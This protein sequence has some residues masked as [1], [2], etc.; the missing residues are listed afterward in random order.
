M[1]ASTLALLALQTG[2]ATATDPRTHYDVLAYRLELAFDPGARAMTASAGKR[3]IRSAR[4]QAVWT[5]NQS[6]R[7]TKAAMET[8]DSTS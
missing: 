1:I 6:L 4:A 7:P 2:S 8:V 3:L 5:K